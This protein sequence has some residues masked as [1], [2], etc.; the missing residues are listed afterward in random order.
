MVAGFEGNKAETRTML[1]VISAFMAV[2][3]PP[4]VTVVADA[5]M[6]SEAN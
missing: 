6:V 5:G 3:D 2:H 1:A 4:D